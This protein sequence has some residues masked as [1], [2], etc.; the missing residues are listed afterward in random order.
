I[1]H[2]AAQIFSSLRDYKNTI[3]HYEKAYKLSPDN[4][5]IATEYHETARKI[6]DWETCNKLDK[7]IDLMLSKENCDFLTMPLTSILKNT[8]PK[9]NQEIARKYTI[10]NTKNILSIAKPFTHNKPKSKNSKLRIGY[11]SSDIKRHPISYLLRGVFQHHDKESFEIYLYCTDEKDNSGYK[12]AIESCADCVKY[13]DDISAYEIAKNIYDDEIDILIDLNGHTGKSWIESLCLKP[14][15]VQ[16][17]YLGFIGT[18]GADFI[19]YIIT[20]EIVT[21]P[22]IQ[23]F[24][25]E[26]FYYMPN[27]YQANDDKLQISDKEITHKDENLPEDAFIFCCFNQAMKIDPL[28]FESWMRILKNVDNSV[29]WLFGD[30]MHEGENLVEKNLSKEAK[31]HGIDPN[32]LIFAKYASLNEHLKRISLADIALDTRIYNGGTVTSNM[33]WAGVPVLTLQGT[34]FASRMSSSILTAIGLEELITHNIEDYEKMAIDLGNNRKKIKSLKS[35]I[36]SNRKS[37]PLFDTKGFT[38]DLEKAYKD[39]AKK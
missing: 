37:S 1:F 38:K 7:Q 10:H 9:I 16:V 4:I 35:K 24:Y 23:K 20:D 17:S 32:R 33:L 3:K 8:D 26:K 18:M 30:N 13:V 14:A 2:S 36:Q 15:A 5:Q 31:K 34:H 22:D 21:P 27:S 39:M 11:I 29:L 19:D 6:C 28:M 12:K 25:N